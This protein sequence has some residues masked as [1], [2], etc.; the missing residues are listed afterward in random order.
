LS[1]LIQLKTERKV[2]EKLEETSGIP[3]IGISASNATTHTGSID[4]PPKKQAN[5]S[6]P[7]ATY[8][9]PMNSKQV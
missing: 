2:V 5:R 7:S 8:K 9:T 3:V 1:V 6:V 4:N